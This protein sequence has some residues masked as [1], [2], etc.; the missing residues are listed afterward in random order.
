MRQKTIFTFKSYSQKGITESGMASGQ[1]LSQNPANNGE[2]KTLLP[3]CL[4]ASDDSDH[5][6]SGG[7]H[8]PGNFRSIWHIVLRKLKVIRY[9]PSA[10][11]YPCLALLISGSAVVL[12][13]LK[14][15]CH[16]FIPGLTAH[17]RCSHHVRQ[18]LRG[19]ETFMRPRATYP[20]EPA[21]WRMADLRRSY[22]NILS[23]LFGKK[24][25]D[26]SDS[27]GHPNCWPSTILGNFQAI[28]CLKIDWKGRTVS[29]FPQS[30]TGIG[31]PPQNELTSRTIACIMQNIVMS[32]HFSEQCTKGFTTPSCLDS[33]ISARICDGHRRGL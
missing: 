31:I 9:R 25:S 24:G 11:F 4:P 30:R 10:L 5:R 26:C 21:F 20:T 14:R 27:K 15:Q 12:A 2:W 3:M 16:S 23:V 29:L 22:G 18:L 19:P 13:I 8:R 33:H 28:S 6:D 1:I 17:Y 32:G 7:S